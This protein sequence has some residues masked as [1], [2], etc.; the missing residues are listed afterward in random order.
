MK[1]I[2]RIINHRPHT[3]TIE[4]KNLLVHF[5]VK[6]KTPHFQNETKYT[7]SLVKMS[8]ISHENENHSHKAEHLT[9]SWYRGPG[10]L[11]NGL[12]VFPPFGVPRFAKRTFT[13]PVLQNHGLRFADKKTLLRDIKSDSWTTTT[14]T[15]KKTQQNESSLLIREEILPK[16]R[17]WS[18]TS[19]M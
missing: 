5:R 10:E 15:K 8:F 19:A 7:A 11:G 13:T 18:L 9:S 16:D 3:K 2:N 17:S 12:S 1:S 14:A 4:K 6:L